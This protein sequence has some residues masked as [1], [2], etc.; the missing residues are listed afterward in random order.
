MKHRS[1][2]MDNKLIQDLMPILVV[3]LPTIKSHLIL[4]N[5]RQI[6]I[7]KFTGVVK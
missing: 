5:Y 6:F 3:K 4:I 1:L 2:A 7:Y